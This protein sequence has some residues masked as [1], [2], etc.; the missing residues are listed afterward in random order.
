[1]ADAL[2][3]PGPSLPAPCRA[4]RELAR[5]AVRHLYEEVTLYPKPGLVS[6]VDTGSHED[7]DASTFVRS[8]FSLRAYFADIARAGAELAPFA[9]LRQLGMDAER[10]MLLAT[11]GINT[12]RGAIFTLGMLCAAAAASRMPSS[13][14]EPGDIR[15]ALLSHWGAALADHRE[16]DRSHGALARARYGIRGARDEAAAGFP[17]VFEIALP[18]LRATLNG[19]RGWRCARVDAFF[20]LMAGLEDTNVYHRG[21]LE[22]ARLVRQEAN[23]FLAAGGTAQPDWEAQAIACHRRFVAKRLSPGGAADLLAA[24]TFVHEATRSVSSNHP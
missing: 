16:P 8:L 13:R 1:M 7:M 21:G 24:A 6:L 4:P 14:P 23:A 3:R 15:D 5:L 12:H 9:A 22:G 20:A 19:G 18:R 17:A 11:G 10:R 2:P